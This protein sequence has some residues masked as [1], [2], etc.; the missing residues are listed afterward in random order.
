MASKPLHPQAGWWRPS[1]NTSNPNRL[2][3]MVPLPHAATT[4]DFV[5]QLQA[6]VTPKTQITDDLV[7]ALIW[8]FNT[9]QPNQG[10]I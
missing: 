9:H 4:D 3:A 7:D 2:F 6:L 1:G 10:G 8:W 5:Q